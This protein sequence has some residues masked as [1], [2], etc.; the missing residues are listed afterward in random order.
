MDD[1]FSNVRV[2]PGDIFLTHDNSE[3]GDTIRYFERLRSLEGVADYNHAGV[4]TSC[5]GGTLEALWRVTQG[6]LRTEYAGE[7]VL[8][9]RHA[10]MDWERFSLGWEAVG[11]RVGEMYP[12][13]RLVLHALG[14]GKLIHWHSVV[15][16]ELVV[17][18]LDISLRGLGFNQFRDPYGWEPSDLELVIREWRMFEIVFEGVI[19]GGVEHKEAS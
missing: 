9:G 10:Q 3:V 1:A 17:E 15:C 2:Q 12:V 16:S 6:N 5:Q 19:E 4:L 14:L 8:I 11:K 18:F 13:G 7:K